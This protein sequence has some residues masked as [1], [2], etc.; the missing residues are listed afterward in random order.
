MTVCDKILQRI[1]TATGS[2][3][4]LSG[5]DFA[6]S[7]L[8][9]AEWAVIGKALQAKNVNELTIAFS[10]ANDFIGHF[11]SGFKD[12]D[13]ILTKLSVSYATLGECENALLSST[14]SQLQESI[15]SL[16]LTN[17][18]F[19]KNSITKLS[20]IFTGL[21]NANVAQL[22]LSGT[23][24]GIT[25]IADLKKLFSTLPP[26]V[27][28]LN[29]SNCSLGQ[30]I[31]QDFKAFLQAFPP[32]VKELNLS[33]NNISKK[34]AK[35]FTDALSKSVSGVNKIILTKNDIANSDSKN[36][37]EIVLERISLEERDKAILKMAQEVVD[38]TNELVPV[39]ANFP[40]TYVTHRILYL[41]LSRKKAKT[42]KEKDL[43]NAI[44][45]MQ[46]D[47]RA[48]KSLLPVDVPLALPD[49]NSPPLTYYQLLDE[50]NKMPPEND[51]VFSI[52]KRAIKFGIG[53]CHENASLAFVLLEEYKNAN[54]ANTPLE[55]VSLQ[56]EDHMFILLNRDS[57]TNL[58]DPA[59]WNDDV[60]IC[61]PY[62]NAVYTK[63]DILQNKLHP[64][65]HWDWPDLSLSLAGRVGER[66]SWD[67][68]KKD[69][70]KFWLPQTLFRDISVTRH[71]KK[72][73]LVEGHGQPDPAKMI[74]WFYMTIRPERHEA[75]LNFLSDGL[76]PTPED[77][78]RIG[79]DGWNAWCFLIGSNGIEVLIEL[80]KRNIYPSEQDLQPINL[81]YKT[82]A[83]NYLTCDNKRREIMLTLLERNIYP[84]ADDLN[85]KGV[86]HTEKNN[87][88]NWLAYAAEKN[89][90][91]AKKIINLLAQRG[92]LPSKGD[93]NFEEI[94]KHI[95][96]TSKN[97][98]R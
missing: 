78:R 74:D 69:P 97:V 14:F 25:S 72:P 7:E 92:I 19:N 44:Y 48:E 50:I 49:I 28:S 47:M 63:A 32:H 96:S 87:G 31:D 60:I 39:S 35:D 88:W 17:N 38:K 55:L 65:Q 54:L 94:T 80:F 15:T 81:K 18:S 82:N 46:L 76:Q 89:E 13:I 83:W 93:P 56:K 91:L 37:N 86:D 90:D 41:N 43:R 67:F 77:L 66:K 22:D 53:N 95:E 36:A 84:A 3:F 58:K 75:F 2:N 42:P 40:M 9:S 73:P 26:T 11:A 62:Y 30:L 52:A 8:T 20:S 68:L 16:G 1:S 24:L 21:Q 59:T 29:L 85:L 23:V 51:M 64:H 12:T 6:L 34:N 5:I 27:T 45:N 10:K 70:N 4:F 61:D 98:K 71:V 57:K 33:Y 79:L